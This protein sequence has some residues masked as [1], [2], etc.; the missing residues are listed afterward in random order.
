MLI[1][2]NI[3][4]AHFRNLAKKMRSVVDSGQIIFGVQNCV[5][6]RNELLTVMKFRSTC[7]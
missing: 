7:I 3:D 5:I 2:L 4:Q 6:E 1:V